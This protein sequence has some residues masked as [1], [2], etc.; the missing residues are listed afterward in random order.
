MRIKKKKIYSH[1]TTFY[2]NVTFLSNHNY[3]VINYR[4]LQHLTME[5]IKILSLPYTLFPY[6]IFQVR[7]FLK[8][9]EK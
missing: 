2:K 4:S 5:N 1:F 7:L 8:T 9:T 3:L 6:S